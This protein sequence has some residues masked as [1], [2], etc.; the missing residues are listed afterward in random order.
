MMRRRLVW[1]AVVAVAVA[2]ALTAGASAVRPALAG[3]TG[4]SDAVD[5]GAASKSPLPEGPTSLD[6]LL[7]T[8]TIAPAPE[9]SRR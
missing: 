4:S 2:I 3:T 8:A 1:L 7:R 5:V 6:A 9:V